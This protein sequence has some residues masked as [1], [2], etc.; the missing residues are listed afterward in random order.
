MKGPHLERSA[1]LITVPPMSG[2]FFMFEATGWPPEGW[3]YA[4]Q[5]CRLILPKNG[6]VATKRGYTSTL[7]TPGNRTPPQQ[8]FLQTPHKHLPLTRTSLP[9][10]H[11]KSFIDHR[12]ITFRNRIRSHKLFMKSIKINIISRRKFGQFTI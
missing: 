3:C 8:K 1:S 6:R 2:K 11:M 12:A 4:T 10:K 7:N 9:V 5:S